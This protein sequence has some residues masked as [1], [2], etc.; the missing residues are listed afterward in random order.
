MIDGLAKVPSVEIPRTAA[1]EAA[2]ADSVRYLASDA[3][4]A[5]LER[6][7]YWPKWDSPWWHTRSSGFAPTVETT[8]LLKFLISQSLK[9]TALATM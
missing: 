3:A 9:V 2:I 6:D 5:S 8:W 7:V 4:V 1:I